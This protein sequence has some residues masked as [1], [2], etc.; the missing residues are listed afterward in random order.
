[1]TT[2]IPE[3]N[4]EI[5]ATTPRATQLQ[6]KLAPLQPDM[7]IVQVP[8]WLMFLVHVLISVMEKCE[9]CLPSSP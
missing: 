9:T 1:M 6:L 5:P 3:F 4:R 7:H 2:F 8:A